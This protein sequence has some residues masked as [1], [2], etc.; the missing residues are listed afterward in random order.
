MREEFGS[1]LRRHRKLRGVSLEEIS[2]VTKI[3]QRY[4]RALEEDDQGEL[5]D[6]VFVK[7]YIRAYAG[8]I[9]AD[10]NELLIAYDENVIAPRRRE[11]VE[12]QRRLDE[13]YGQKKKK[14][15]G[16]AIGAVL[17]SGLIA[18]VVWFDHKEPMDPTSKSKGSVKNMVAESVSAD[19][20]PLADVPQLDLDSDALSKE[21]ALEQFQELESIG[22]EAS[23]GR[24]GEADNRAMNAASIESSGEEIQEKNTA[25]SGENNADM[26]NLDLASIVSQTKAK[27]IFDSIPENDVTIQAHKEDSGGKVKSLRLVIRVREEGWFNLIIDGSGEKDFILPAGA[28]KTFRAKSSIKVWIG[29]KHGTELILNDKA[30]KLPESSDN[31]IRDFTVTAKLLE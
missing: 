26:E 21:E 17:I 8:S 19:L 25:E 3:P 22:S 2:S 5:P 1:Y 24:S 13:S 31:V 7:G 27:E 28:S 30:L 9:G 16:G 4:L 10:V 12:H 14:I 6:E 11:E 29:N 20:N 23:P 15:I 18:T